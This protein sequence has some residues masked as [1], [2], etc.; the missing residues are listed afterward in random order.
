MPRRI[1]GVDD[2]EVIVVDD[3]SS[4]ETALHALAAG[5][6]L[7]VSHRGNRGLVST[8]ADGMHAALQG[9]ADVVGHL[10]GDG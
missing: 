3:G 7:I 4:D 2:V 8:F 1:D 5:A 6:D 10:D 9:G